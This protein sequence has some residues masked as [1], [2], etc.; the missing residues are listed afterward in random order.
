MFSIETYQP[1]AQSRSQNHLESDDALGG[2]SF[3]HHA[4]VSGI[5]LHQQNTQGE[6]IRRQWP[7]KRQL[8]PI[9][10][11]CSDFRAHRLL[12]GWQGRGN[13][14]QSW[15]SGASQRTPGR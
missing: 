15:Y 5:I 6:L 10:V 8:H 14:P 12:S 3:P 11:I 2:K 4:S 1:F 13:S 7:Q 9:L